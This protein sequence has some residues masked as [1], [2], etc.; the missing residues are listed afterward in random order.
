[1]GREL[2]PFRKESDAHGFM[3]DHKGKILL[4][5]KEVSPEIVKG[6]D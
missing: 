4:K 1:M 6:L 5:F 3:K 2:I